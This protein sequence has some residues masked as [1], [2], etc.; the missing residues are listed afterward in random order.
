MVI[1]SICLTHVVLC[2]LDPIWTVKTGSLFLLKLTTEELFTSN[3]LICEVMD[4]DKFGANDKLGL[5]TIPPK[6]LFEGKG[7]RLEYDLLP[8]KGAEKVSVSSFPWSTV[9]S[10]GKWLTNSVSK[11]SQHREVLLSDFDTPLTMILSS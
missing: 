6:V 3:G 2:S 7:E 1:E 8:T 10:L 5:I 9:V 4:F 11:I